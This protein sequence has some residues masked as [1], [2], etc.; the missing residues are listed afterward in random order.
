MMT[1]LKDLDASF[2]LEYFMCTYSINDAIKL[3]LIL[4]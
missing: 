3:N 2:A 1:L 4:Y